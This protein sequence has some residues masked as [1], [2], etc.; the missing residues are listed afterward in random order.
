MTPMYCAHGYTLARIVLRHRTEVSE[1]SREKG[2]YLFEVHVIKGKVKTTVTRSLPLIARWPAGIK[3]CT[4]DGPHLLE[5][6]T[7]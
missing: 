5:R 1:V 3:K 2:T 7:E 6:L 4:P